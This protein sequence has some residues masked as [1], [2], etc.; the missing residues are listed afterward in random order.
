MEQ[1]LP[2]VLVL[3]ADDIPPALSTWLGERGAT[4]LLV[5]IELMSD[6]ALVLQTL[7]DVDPTLVARIRKILAE[8]ADVLRRLT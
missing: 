4:A 6:G 5:S 1:T 3:P 8:H 2:E 7:P